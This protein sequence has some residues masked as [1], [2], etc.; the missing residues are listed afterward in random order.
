MGNK[1]K[2]HFW[3]LPR[4]FATPFFASSCL[5]GSVLSAGL[6]RDAWIAVIAS[7]LVMA[8]GHSFNSY[9]DY[10]WT[11]LD[12]GE[13]GDRSAEKD[14]AG[15]QNVISA[16]IVS[17]RE[18]LGNALGWYALSAIPVVYLAI[19]VSSL[20]YIP[21]VLG[22]LVTFWYSWAKFNYTHELALGVAVGPLPALLGAYGASAHPQIVNSLLAS[23]PVAI[24][25]SFIGL[26]LDEW[27]DAE[28]N[29]KKG[30]KSIAY[31][32]WQYSNFLPLETTGESAEPEK[33]IS[34]LQ[35]YC[36]A[37]LSI[38]YLFQIFLI[39]IGVLRPLTG[40][41]FILVPFLLAMLVVMKGDFRR[42]MRFI[43]AI[44]AAFPV[45]MVVAQILG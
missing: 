7:I 34:G 8:G 19:T 37:W 38:L 17:L 25:L 21:W 45:I 18:V 23:I 44:A 22:M 13:V 3:T 39:V 14:Y 32:V 24:I 16:G 33:D 12:K 35:W 4:W 31:M 26:A 36:T 20:V 40:W 29:L 30:V 43:V 6:N 2:V 1:I 41:T 27:P 42:S 11:G 5:M 28:A 10:A 9:L 15:G